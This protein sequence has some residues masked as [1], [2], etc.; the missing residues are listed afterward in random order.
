MDDNTLLV[1][2]FIIIS[3][4]VM[5]ILALTTFKEWLNNPVLIRFEMD[6]NMLEA[7]KITNQNNVITEDKVENATF[8]DEFPGII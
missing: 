3:I 8:V 5:M 6:D 4:S 7:L 2:F 1:W